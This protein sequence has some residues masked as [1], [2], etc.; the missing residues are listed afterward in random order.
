LHPFAGPLFDN[1]GRQVLVTGKKLS[2]PEILSMN[3]LV[4]G[5]QGTL[6][7]P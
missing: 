3:Y 5:V 4:Q 7:K 6:A 2:D 1:E